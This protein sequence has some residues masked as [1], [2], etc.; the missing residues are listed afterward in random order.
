MEFDCQ[1]VE[2]LR[3]SIVHSSG[4]RRYRHYVIIIT[5][6]KTG[7]HHFNTTFQFVGIN[8]QLSYHQLGIWLC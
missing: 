2:M 5:D 6:D 7:I 3:V 8:E 1:N 4:H